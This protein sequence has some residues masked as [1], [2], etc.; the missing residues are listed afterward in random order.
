[1]NCAFDFENFPCIGEFPYSTHTAPG[2]DMG[3]EKRPFSFKQ[4]TDFFVKEEKAKCSH[5]QWSYDSPL[6]YNTI[7]P[8]ALFGLLSNKTNISQWQCKPIKIIKIQI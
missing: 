8:S 4:F 3:R 1:M 6:L 7:W 2:L 5:K